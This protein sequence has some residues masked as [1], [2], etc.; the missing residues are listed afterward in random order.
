MVDR[1]QRKFMLITTTTLFLVLFIFVITLN[2][3]NIIN[4]NRQSDSLLSLI[5]EY[6]GNLPREFK[7]V[8]PKK[9]I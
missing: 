7:D 6:D 8:K 2:L 1:L 4:I 9:Y 5:Q 3:I